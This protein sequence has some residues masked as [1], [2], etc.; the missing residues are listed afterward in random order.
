[1]NWEAILGIFFMACGGIALLSLA[2]L[3]IITAWDIRKGNK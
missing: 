1:M 2:A 3:A